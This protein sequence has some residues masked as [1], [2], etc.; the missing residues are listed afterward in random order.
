[1]FNW[2]GVFSDT[3][4][5]LVVSWIRHLFEGSCD[6]LTT[7]WKTIRIRLDGRAATCTIPRLRKKKVFV[8]NFELLNMF[9]L[10]IFVEMIGYF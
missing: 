5:K 6:E 9:V 4:F 8:S 10:N 1:M 3:Y 2:S 7:Y